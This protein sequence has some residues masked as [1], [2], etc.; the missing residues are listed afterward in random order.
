MSHLAWVYAVITL[1]IH[2]GWDLAAHRGCLVSHPAW[3]LLGNHPGDTP[4]P[5]LGGTPGLPRES[6]G[7]DLPGKHPGDT[8]RLGLGGTPGTYP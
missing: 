8:P 6:P 4:R 1:A 3:D 5:G 2:H 7:L